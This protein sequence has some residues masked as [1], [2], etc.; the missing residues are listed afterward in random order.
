MTK[1]LTVAL[2]MSLLTSCSTEKKQEAVVQSTSG[3]NSPNISDGT[4]GQVV[5]QSSSGENSPNI[6]G[7]AGNVVI[8]NGEVQS[9]KR[10]E[11]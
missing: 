1:I 5:V 4:E 2:F 3:D 6:S 8:I 10:N 7:A 11:K 9:P